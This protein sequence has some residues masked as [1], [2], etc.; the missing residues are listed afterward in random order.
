[1]VQRERE[2]LAARVNASRSSFSN[3]KLPKRRQTR[4][5]AIDTTCIRCLQAMADGAFEV[6]GRE[7]RTCLQKLNPR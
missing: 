4:I 7:W 5:F 2:N 6:P 3:G 1:L